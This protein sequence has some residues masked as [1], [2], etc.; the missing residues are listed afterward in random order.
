MRFTV[1]ALVIGLLLFA[2]P[3]K[4]QT[5]SGFRHASFNISFD[6]STISREGIKDG[7]NN[8]DLTFKDVSFGTTLPVANRLSIWLTVSKAASWSEADE[9]GRRARG[10]FA[11]GLSYRLAQHNRVSLDV[12]SGVTSR[13]ERLGDGM[14]NPTA[15]RIGGK[16]GIRLLGEPGEHRWFGIFIMLGEDLM[17]RDINDEMKGSTVKGTILSYWRMGFEF[18]L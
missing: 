5:V 2:T 15:L 9:S 16:V 1:A 6:G 10:A 8:P 14:I 18:S 17:L 13:L 12:L 7:L 11:G 4:A 3:S